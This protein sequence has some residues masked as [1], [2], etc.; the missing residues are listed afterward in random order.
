M[1]KILK[2]LIPESIK[3]RLRRGRVLSPNAY[4]TFSQEGEDLILR[5]IFHR[6]ADGF[7]VDVGAH[8]PQCFS[9]TY[10][11][12]L[13]GWRGINIDAMPGSMA[14]FERIRPRDINLEVAV[15][16]RPEKLTYFQFATPGINTF[17]REIM[18]QRLDYG[19]GPASDFKYE[20]VAPAEIAT[21]RLDAILE[22]RLPAGQ[23]VDFL[24]I[25]VEG[26]EMAVLNSCDWS[27]FRPTVVLIEESSLLTLENLAASPIVS[28]MSERGYAPFCRTPL[29][30]IF[31]ERSQIVATPQGPR[32]R[33]IA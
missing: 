11:F 4:E 24:N 6:K 19:D 2:R 27:K 17:S 14:E 15:S 31:V 9:N 7:Y 29:T 3:K 1:K 5:R 32:L 18:E 25:D 22:E 26:F 10:V 16:D 12:Y 13:K 33:A 8:H 28:F 21:R 23:G 30:L 20:L